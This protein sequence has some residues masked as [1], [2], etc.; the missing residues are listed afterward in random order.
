MRSIRQQF[1]FHKCGHEELL[2]RIK[3]GQISVQAVGVYFYLRLFAG[4]ANDSGYIHSSSEARLTWVETVSLVKAYTRLSSKAVSAALAELLTQR[5]LRQYGSNKI[6][7]IDGWEDEQAAAS[8]ET[9]RKREYRLRKEIVRKLVERGYTESEAKTKSSHMLRRPEVWQCLRERGL[10]QDVISKCLSLSGIE[11]VE[12]PAGAPPPASF[13]VLD[14]SGTCPARTEDPE[15]RDLSHE[16]RNRSQPEETFRALSV[17]DSGRSASTSG[18]GGG[19]PAGGCGGG[20]PGEKAR[21]REMDPIQAAQWLTEEYGDWSSNTLKKRLEAGEQKYGRAVA[22]THW[23]SCLEECWTEMQ[24]RENGPQ[25]NRIRN[26]GKFLGHLLH[27]KGF[28][29]GSR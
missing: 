3:P 25:K 15:K 12:A 10:E 21:L 17:S 1:Y 27:K 29:A 22:S 6:V 26:K 20:V 24:M 11:G 4:Q 23:Y 5:L 18:A 7:R 28:L 19:A 9:V 13:S 14:R 16:V 8:K 2:K